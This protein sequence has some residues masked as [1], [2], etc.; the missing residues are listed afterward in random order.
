MEDFKKIEKKGEI[1][2]NISE[3]ILKLKNPWVKI[4]TLKENVRIKQKPEISVYSLMENWN[5]Y[6]EIAIDGMNCVGKSTLCSMM[7]RTKIKINDLYP[8]ITKGPNYNIHSSLSF[9][10]LAYSVLSSGK[11]L[12]WD[13][14]PYSNLIFQLAHYLVGE[15]K[16]Q[17][18]PL[19]FKTIDAKC[20]IFLM[21]TGLLATI[22]I[23]MN[24]KNIPILFI[25][26][27]DFKMISELLIKRGKHDVKDLGNAKWYNYQ[28]AQY[29]AYRFFAKL[30]NMPFIDLNE[31]FKKKETLTDIQ[32]IIKFLI[33]TKKKNSEIHPYETKNHISEIINF[34]NLELLF[35]NSKK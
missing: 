33:D 7:N 31:R 19:C 25:V 11:N 16:D 1:P 4:K 5:K 14:S 34:N 18:I 15:Y 32:L 12:I 28:I 9:E 8:H 24:L 3:K 35:E 30:L 27:S 17:P 21:H 22:S 13:R 29:H 10:Y 23:S 20:I 26:N 6:D 2:E